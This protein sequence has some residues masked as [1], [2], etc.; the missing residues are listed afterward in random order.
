MDESGSEGSCGDEDEKISEFE[1]WDG[2]GDLEE[3][4]DPVE[5]T[6]PMLVDTETVLHATRYI[7]PQLRNRS[8]KGDQPSEALVQLSRQIK[9]LLNRISEQNIATIL[10]SVGELFQKHKRH[11]LTSALAKFIID[12]VSSHSSLLDSFVVIYAAFVSGLHKIV[13]LEFGTL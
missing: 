5:S 3:D 2:I 8:E 13:G 1:E 12:G 7:P 6:P 10:Q 4:I 9:G 11:D